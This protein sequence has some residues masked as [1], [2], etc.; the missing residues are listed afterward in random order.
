MDSATCCI[1]RFGPEAC[2]FSTS[3]AAVLMGGAK[4]VTDAA[5][6][7]EE[8]DDSHN[9]H[10]PEWRREC[11]RAYGDCQNKGWKGDCSACFDYCKGQHEWPINKC[12]PKKKGE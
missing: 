8:W 12:R 4:A 7:T 1:Q 11:I 3:E 6:D 9:S 10:L 5:S 2:G